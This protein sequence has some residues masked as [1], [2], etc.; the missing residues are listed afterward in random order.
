MAGYINRII[1]MGNL[2]KDPEYKKVNGSTSLAMFSLATTRFFDDRN[3]QRQEKTDWHRITVWG[4]QADVI[5]GI[6]HK[7]SSVLVE[8]SLQYNEYTDKDGNQRQGTE[9]VASTIVFC[10]PKEK[11]ASPQGNGWG[12]PQPQQPPQQPPPPQGNGWQSYEQQYQQAQQS[13]GQPAQQPPQPQAYYPRE[14]Y[15]NY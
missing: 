6:L 15:G 14:D 9:I 12:Q 8:G 10:D 7:G 4:K 3:G 2:G 5:K 13:W 11:S 1:L